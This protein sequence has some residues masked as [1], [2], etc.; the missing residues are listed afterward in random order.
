MLAT[1]IDN[2]G[3]DHGHLQA[4]SVCLLDLKGD[5]VRRKMQHQ[6]D[7]PGLQTQAAAVVDRAGGGARCPEVGFHAG[8]GHRCEGVRAGDSAVSGP[9]TRGTRTAPGGE[10]KFHAAIAGKSRK[11]VSRS[12]KEWKQ[13]A[14]AWE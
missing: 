14:A 12:V 7:S 13:L 10:A 2:Q 11:I 6:G 4:G 1:V 9:V 8:P 5:S 3:K